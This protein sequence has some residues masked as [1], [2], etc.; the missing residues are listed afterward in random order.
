MVGLGVRPPVEI[1]AFGLVLDRRRLLTRQREFAGVEALRVAAADDG[2]ED[3]QA[4]FPWKELVIRPGFAQ[5]EMVIAGQTFGTDFETTSARQ[6][7][8]SID[9]DVERLR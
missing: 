4:V 3:F 8:V 1:D 5:E 2:C 6:G 7:I 9:P